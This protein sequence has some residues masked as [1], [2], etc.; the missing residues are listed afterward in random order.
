MRGY[1]AYYGFW[2]G[3]FQVFMAALWAV[4]GFGMVAGIVWA[5]LHGD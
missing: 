3:L 1:W 5:V 2:Y 4:S